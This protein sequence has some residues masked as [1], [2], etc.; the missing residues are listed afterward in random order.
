METLN[1]IFRSV[2]SQDYPLF[3][4]GSFYSKAVSGKKFPL[5]LTAN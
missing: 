4:V 3:G 1:I 2:A 5:R